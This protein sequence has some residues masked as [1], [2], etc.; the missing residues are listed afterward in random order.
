MAANG[1]RVL[2]VNPPCCCTLLQNCHSYQAVSSFIA[3]SHVCLFIWHPIAG[4]LRMVKWQ[5]RGMIGRGLVYVVSQTLPKRYVKLS[6]D[7]WSPMRDSNPG[8]LES[9]ALQLPCLV[10]QNFES[11]SLGFGLC[12]SSG[13]LTTEKHNVPKTGSVSVLRWG[14]GDTC[15][16]P[17]PLLKTETD[18]VSE[19][20]FFPVVRIPYDGKS[21]KT[22]RFWVLS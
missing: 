11:E 13:I 2:N 16:V 9:N 22:Q 18:P 7:S 6:R 14:D 3:H 10:K 15:C 17:S 4:R 8:L 1:I 20:L 5:V 21:K 19:T 12:P